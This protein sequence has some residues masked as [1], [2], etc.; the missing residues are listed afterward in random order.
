MPI[1]HEDDDR[2]R[3]DPYDPATGATGNDAEPE[4]ADAEDLPDEEIEGDG[5]ELGG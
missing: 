5:E 4:E 2:K 3:R 1:A